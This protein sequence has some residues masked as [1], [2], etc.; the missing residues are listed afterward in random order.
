MDTKTS[1]QVEKLLMENYTFLNQLIQQWDPNSNEASIEQIMQLSHQ[2]EK[3]KQMVK[4]I[5]RNRKRFQEIEIVEDES[6][7]IPY[8]SI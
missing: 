5:K 7:S 3:Q 1:Q 8:L 2:A 6:F 4:R